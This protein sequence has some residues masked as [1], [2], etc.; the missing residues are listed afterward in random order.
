MAELKVFHFSGSFSFNLPVL[1][2]ASRIF[3]VDT[4][5]GPES[6]KE[7]VSYC[8]K[9]LKGRKGYVINTHSHFDHV[10]GNSAF[11][12]WDIIC[13]S[14]CYD[15]LK[16]EGKKT[17]TEI[18]KTNPEWVKEKINLVLPDLLFESELNFLDKDSTV[19][20]K[21]LPGHSDDSIIISVMPENILLAG[22]MLEDPFPLLEGKNIE[23][24]LKNLEWLKKQN[25]S[26]VIPSH[27]K[28]DDR[29]LINDNL[30][31]LKKAE[32]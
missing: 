15:I 12:G 17:I 8:K 18:S 2:T 11:P 4:Y 20:I 22:D 3:V 32:R 16:S 26:K 29:E 6:I 9:N 21:Y 10:W 14:S 13:H 25:F 27:G 30:F 28:R 31:Y 7:V 5:M 19:S 1:M 23:V 24:Y